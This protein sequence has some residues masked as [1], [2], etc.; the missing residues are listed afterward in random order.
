L[1]AAGLA[2]LLVAACAGGLPALKRGVAA[3][4]DIFVVY[5]EG[6]VITRVADAPG[7]RFATPREYEAIAETV[8]K[9]LALHLAGHRVRTGGE[10]P[11][12][13]AGGLE[14]IVSVYGGYLCEGGAPEYE[15]GL[16]MQSRLTFR[17]RRTGRIIGPGGNLIGQAWYGTHPVSVPRRRGAGVEHP[18]AQREVDEAIRREIPASLLLGP[19][20][21][22][23]EEGLGEFLRTLQAAEG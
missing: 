9:T 15:C 18:A 22:A 17:S 8:R 10:P 7:A 5:G 4:S 14:A 13:G 12:R 21:S 19:L 23:T 3:E 16:T 11:E 20:E 1:A 2:A 6:S